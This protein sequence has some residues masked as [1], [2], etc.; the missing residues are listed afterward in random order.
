MIDN[1]DDVF[2]IFDKQKEGFVKDAD[3]GTILRALNF[4]PTD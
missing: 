3:L 2:D 4:N 1:V